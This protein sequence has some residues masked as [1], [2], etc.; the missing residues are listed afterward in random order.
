MAN[1][2]HL[3]ILEQGVEAWNAWREANPGVQPDLA[4]AK[5]ADRD[6]RGIDL[7]HAK[8]AHAALSNANLQRARLD[9][10]DLTG[11]YLDEATFAGPE[12]GGPARRR[13]AELPDA[14]LVGAH[15]V[16]AYLSGANL[17]RAQ[18]MR[19]DLGGAVL[20]Q[21]DLSDADLTGAD[22]QRAVMV[23]TKLSRATLTG[24]KVYGL[25][26]W[27]LAL[28]G[29]VQRNLVITRENEPQVTVD[30]LE[31]AQFLHLLLRNEKIRDVIDTITTK[32]VLIL[33]RFT[34]GRKAVLDALR[35]ELRSRDYLPVLFDFEKPAGR[36]IT[37]TVSL[38]ARMARFV[39]ADITDARSIPQ[40]LGV[41]VPTCR[42]SRCS[43]CCWRGAAST[44]CSST[45]GVTRGCCRCTSTRPP[46]ADRGS[47]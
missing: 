28:D 19:A 36:D 25:S 14:R 43:P 38:L 6:L 27:G 12:R 7:R 30:N 9:H 33:G 47:R 18:L 2:E 11:A 44:G 42:P 15:L 1:E 21:S 39:V 16:G 8:L 31:V 35:D 22:L 40:E 20:H 5:L 32:V 24:C 41:I 26:A 45:S 3:A 10:A 13:G 17:A 46:S 29:A 37:E 34:P 23:E 4:R